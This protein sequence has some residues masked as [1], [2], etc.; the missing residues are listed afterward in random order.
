MQHKTVLTIGITNISKEMPARLGWQV[1]SQLNVDEALAHLKSGASFDATL[2]ALPPTVSSP[3]Q[4][5]Q[6]LRAQAI[7]SL[8]V[9]LDS[10]QFSSCARELAESGVNEVLPGPLNE[11]AFESLL[12]R[13]HRM[14]DLLAENQY[15]RRNVVQGMEELIGRSESW[16]KL[17]KQQE[18]LVSDN[19]HVLLV[20]ETGTGISALARALHRRSRQASGALICVDCAAWP[21]SLLNTELFGNDHC[22]EKRRPACFDLACGGTL[23]VTAVKEMS[24]AVQGKLAQAL[25]SQRP[26]QADSVRVIC[27]STTDL[28]PAVRSG[29]FLQE[30]FTLLTPISVPS[31][32]E[33]SED[34]L[35]LAEYFLRQASDPHARARL[36]LDLDAKEALLQYTWPGNV[37][38][39][40]NV[41]ERALIASSA[42]AL[43]ASDLGLALKNIE[44]AAP[45]TAAPA[46]VPPATTELARSADSRKVTFSVGQPL[47]EIEYEMLVRTL[48]LARG[49][50][51]KTAA[52]LGISVRT[53]YS[54]IL[55]IEHQ[56][57]TAAKTPRT[58]NAA[59]LLKGSQCDLAHA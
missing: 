18:P 22:G 54:K 33:R 34:K 43:T 8:T 50:R 24:L 23:V 15:H 56:R 16:L 48:E 46:L 9:V 19:K 25:Q 10:E 2:V 37:R 52:I 32:R 53:L 3:R 35:L 12:L 20:G 28:A 1:S 42:P 49:N 31:L 41:I 21:D 55:E 27:L 38:E 29:A 4:F 59:D 13:A 14:L 36:S 17:C 44:A 58:A 40:K 26:N 30:L 6:L 5:L 11:Q 51:T 57:E 7:G 39:L 47:H 45:R